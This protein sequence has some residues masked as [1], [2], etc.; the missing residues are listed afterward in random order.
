M[1]RHKCPYFPFTFEDRQIV[2]FLNFKVNNQASII[3]L[4]MTLIVNGDVVCKKNC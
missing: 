4:K 3:L 2:S 1:F